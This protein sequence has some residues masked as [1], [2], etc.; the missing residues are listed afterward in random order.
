MS[1]KIGETQNCFG[2]KSRENITLHPTKF[3]VKNGFLRYD[4][5]KMDIGNRSINFGGTVG[6]SDKSLDMKVLLP[7][8]GE[9]KVT[10][11][12]KGTINKPELDLAGLLGETLQ[13]Q[14]E[15]ELQEQL[16]EELKEKIM[17]E[18]EKLFE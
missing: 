14:L 2:G 3:T 15:D 9:K 4:D 8:R 7:Y 13:Q 1:L 17:E 12:L 16:G 11:P 5:M 10:V 6:L 18:L